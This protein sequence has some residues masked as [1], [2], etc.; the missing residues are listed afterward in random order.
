MIRKR[1][2]NFSNS[3]RDK[4]PSGDAAWHFEDPQDPYARPICRN[5]SKYHY[6]PDGGS[7]FMRATFNP[8]YVTCE[9]CLAI[10]REKG[11]A[12]PSA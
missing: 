10:I 12:I 4:D 8:K 11:I 5:P 1:K 2:I 7:S 9:K 6:N 3:G